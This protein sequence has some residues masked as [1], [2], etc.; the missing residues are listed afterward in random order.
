[1]TN[2]VSENGKTKKL[3]TKEMVFVEN[4]L[5]TW[6]PFKAAS[7][8]SYK[9]PEKQA[10]QIM[11]RPLVKAAIQVRLNELAMGA[12]EVIARLNQ[13]AV[14]NKSDFYKFKLD[15]N[16]NPIYTDINWEE[17]QKRGYLI[18]RLFFD[19]NGIPTIEFHDNLK[20]LELLGKYQGLEDTK[21]DIQG[22]NET[23]RLNGLPADLISP[24]F[25]NAY[26]DIR[27]RLHTE[28]LFFGGRGSTKSSF[29]SLVMIW[30]LIN[31][32]GVHGLALRQVANTL[33]DSVYAQLVWAVNELGMSDYFSCTTSPMEITYLPTEQ[34]IYFRGADDPGK[35]KSIKTK[36]G[37]IGLLWFEELDQFHGEEAIRKIEQSVMRGGDFFLEFK[38][39]NPPRTANNWANKYAQ[40]PKANQYQHKS[41][42]L[43][44]P[45]EWLGKT[46][47]EEAEHLKLVNPKAYEHEYLGIS[48]GT[49]GLV[50]ENV[51]LRP[52]PDD[53][54]IT[55]GQWS[56][57]LDW[58]YFP[59]PLA[60]GRMYYNPAQ[61]TL[62]I[63]GEYRSNKQGNRAAFDDLV[64]AGLIRKTEYIDDDGK[65][66]VSFPD[67]I[68]ADSAEPKS[69]ADFSSYG[70]NIRGAE[71][72]PDSVDYSIKWL[73]SLKAI[74]I[75]PV[76][77]PNHAEEFLNYELE[78]DKDGNFISSYPDKN[79][80]F[81]DDTRYATNLIWRR[82]GQ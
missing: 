65:S 77:C 58:G 2:D 37:H 10:Y 44:V 36:F 5:T 81:I 27:N 53:E 54:I 76:R 7:A 32:P 52:I 22:A 3:T 59:D 49:G 70:A 74:V 60:Y 35:I 12:N 1:M 78:Q 31:N 64:K 48:N 66:I 30:Q 68:I 41:D 26:R 56:H 34:K 73:Q 55:F 80:H 4:F 11:Q 72:G 28:Y 20:A 47:F 21:K 23:G 62:Y 40:I 29:I 13:Q 25:F 17:F 9:Q 15:E 50:F 45:P 42:Y 69:I 14:V 82:R 61:M 79:N 67:L 19:R 38:S 18:K 57:G 43:T 33:R 39:W 51:I 71:K 46:F 75:D 6:S 8:A 24:N 16:G 63:F